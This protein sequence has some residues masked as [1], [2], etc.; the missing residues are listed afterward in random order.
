VKIQELSKSQVI[1]SFYEVPKTFAV[2][3]YQ[4]K[5]KKKI[6]KNVSGQ[7]RSFNRLS[8]FIKNITCA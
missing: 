4:N 6:L 3:K 1:P 2:E 7:N 5:M 8:F